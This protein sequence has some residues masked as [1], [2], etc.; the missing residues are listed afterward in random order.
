MKKTKRV[1]N[2]EIQCWMQ[3]KQK[4]FY[5]FVMKIEP[6]RK[7]FV[8]DRGDM[9]GQTV[10]EYN[11][12]KSWKKLWKKLDAEYKSKTFIEERETD[13]SVLIPT[14]TENYIAAYEDIDEFNYLASEFYF[15]LQIIPGVNIE[16][17]LD[18]VVSLDGKTI[19][20]KEIKC[21]SV[22]PSIAFL[23]FNTQSILYEWALLQMGYKVKST[24]WDI[25]KAKMPGEA[26]LTTKGLLSKSKVDSTYFQM[27]KSLK[28]LGLDITDPEIAEYLETFGYESYFYRQ[29]IPHNKT[30]SRNLIEEIKKIAIEIK[31][32]S[33]IKK[34]KAIGYQ[35][36][37][38]E[39]RNLCQSELQG[40]NTRSILA[41][42]Y[43]ESEYAKRKDLNRREKAK[44][45]QKDVIPKSFKSK[46]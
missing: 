45:K 25:I 42:E 34:E 5:Q 39:F 37:R 6:K 19:S 2:S 10:Q 40:V 29:E 30:V 4:H 16:G 12:G 18:E 7:L 17:N 33:G 27:E 15:D 8:F 44:E 35:C 13:L 38:C 41:I 23:T 31:M 24:V 11:K 21:Y 43:Q 32:Y 46:K 26:K 3:C 1:S 28:K 36:G 9:I 22:F 14:L 20:N